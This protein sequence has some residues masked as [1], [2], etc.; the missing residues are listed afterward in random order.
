MAANGTGRRVAATRKPSARA[1]VAGKGRAARVVPLASR[2]RPRAATAKP[3]NDG[4]LRCAK[5]GSSF[6]E[7]EPA[8]VHCRYCGALARIPHASMAEQELYEIRSGLRLAS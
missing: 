2:R 3:V 8:F 5:C 7:R 4:I 1:A 6:V